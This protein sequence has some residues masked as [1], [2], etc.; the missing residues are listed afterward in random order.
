MVIVTVSPTFNLLTFSC[1]SGIVFVSLLP[2]FKGEERPEPDYFISGLDKFRMFRSGDHKI[3]RLNGGPWE[4]YNMAN[5]PSETKNLAES[6]PDKLKELSD[7][8]DRVD[9]ELGLQKK[10]EK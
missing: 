3:V 1:I 2:I 10:F 6:A 7:Y 5:D 9:G 4:L 8:F